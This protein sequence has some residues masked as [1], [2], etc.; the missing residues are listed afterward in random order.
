M[1]VI[2]NVFKCKPGHTSG[3]IERFEQVAAMQGLG[4]HRILID[5]VATFWTVVLETEVEDL[6]EWER[7]FQE[8]G[9]RRD[10]RAAMEGYMEDVVEGY[11]EVF[12]VLK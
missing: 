6:A 4:R 11:R 7:Q 12:R 3:I 9:E 2:R 5:H 1:Y 10:V 8:Y